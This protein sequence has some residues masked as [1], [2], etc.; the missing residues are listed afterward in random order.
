MDGAFLFIHVEI[1]PAHHNLWNLLGP[2]AASK[3][4]LNLDRKLQGLAEDQ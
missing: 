2:E 4:Y 1:Y 3:S